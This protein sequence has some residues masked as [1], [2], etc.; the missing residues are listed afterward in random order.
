MA[1]KTST[2]A[3]DAAP[4]K[5]ETLSKAVA[6]RLNITPASAVNRLQA[7]E[8]DLAATGA[9]NAAAA[10]DATDPVVLA[11]CVAQNLD[12]RN[13]ARFR[14]SMPAPPAAA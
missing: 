11:I 10:I 2:A 1:K 12:E 9:A 3:A 5:R 7:L 6:A 14:E 4:S 13:L 8:Q